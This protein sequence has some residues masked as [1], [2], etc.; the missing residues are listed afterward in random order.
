AQVQYR[1]VRQP[2]FPYWWDSWRWG[3]FYGEEM[4]ILNG[5]AQTDEKGMVA[6]EFTAL[7]DLSIPEDKLPV[8]NYT[9][10]LDVTDIRGETRSAQTSV[11]VGYV[12]LSVSL[13]LPETVDQQQ[14]PPVTITSENL[15]GE[16]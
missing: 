4:E 1:V 2:R 10:Y 15:N 13:D 11:Q 12:A 14:L 9:V 5:V 8:F 3:G 16:F 7:P 6:V